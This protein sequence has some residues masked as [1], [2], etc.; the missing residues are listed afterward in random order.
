M[1]RKSR[2]REDVSASV[3]CERG[4]DYGGG[5]R[6]GR[7]SVRYGGSGGAGEGGGVWNEHIGRA[8]WRIMDAREIDH[9]HFFSFPFLVFRRLRAGGGSSCPITV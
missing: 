2:R 5:L 1:K 6:Y 4:E 7:E 9:L 8:Y 3:V